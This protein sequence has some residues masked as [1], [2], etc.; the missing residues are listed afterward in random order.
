[1]KKSLSEKIA[2]LLSFSA[3]LFD[4]VL[5]RDYMVKLVVLANLGG[6]VFGFYWY[7]DLLQSRPIS[8]WPLIPDSPLSTLFIAVSLVLY[9][10]GN[11]SKLLDALAFVGNLKYGL[12]TFF[13][14]IY[15]FQEL[16]ATT[17]L[18]LYLFITISHLLMFLQA[19]LVLRYS[20]LSL[21]AGI[22]VVAWFI[23]NDFVDYSLGV[24]ATLPEQMSIFSVVS[25]VAFALTLVSGLIYVREALN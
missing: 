1:M 4:Q 12:W 19:F 24:H 13:V 23:I 6:T 14:Q 20:D 10:Y 17:S 22:L 7:R 5:E 11:S 9:L 3:N 21:K 18:P 2:A 16:M 25:A 8:L 15:F